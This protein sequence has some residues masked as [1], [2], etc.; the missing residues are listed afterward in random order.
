MSLLGFGIAL[1]VSSC[2]LFGNKAAGSIDTLKNDSLKHKQDS[3]KKVANT[4]TP[5]SSKKDSTAKK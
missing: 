4:A 1:S 2:N 3:L 5:D